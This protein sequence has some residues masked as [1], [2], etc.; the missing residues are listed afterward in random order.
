MSGCDAIKAVYTKESTLVSQ[1][2]ILR[3]LRK[4][5]VTIIHSA[6]LKAHLWQNTRPGEDSSSRRSKRIDQEGCQSACSECR[7]ERG[8]PCSAKPKSSFQIRLWNTNNVW[9]YQ[10]ESTNVTGCDACLLYSG[11]NVVGRGSLTLY[12]STPRSLSVKI[13]GGINQFSRKQLSCSSTG[14]IISG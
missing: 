2:L 1:R 9:K 7:G 6:H 3:R 13:R 14:D 10:E 12:T 4:L 11:I 8:K 5:Y